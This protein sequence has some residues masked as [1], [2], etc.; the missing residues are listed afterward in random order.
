MLVQSEFE[1]MTCTS[2]GLPVEFPH[3]ARARSQA[4]L[5][6]TGRPKT[7]QMLAL[8]VTSVAGTSNGDFRQLCPSASATSSLRPSTAEHGWVTS[9]V[10]RRRRGEQKSD[11]DVIAAPVARTA[12]AGRTSLHSSYAGNLS[13]RKGSA[14]AT[15]N[16]AS[17]QDQNSRLAG[18][19]Q[20]PNAP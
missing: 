13:S 11:S 15:R 7:A 6:A 10:S 3:T 1:A 8:N 18:T 12:A 16:V 14:G 19:L 17:T 20:P 9:S 4:S 2:L 5:P